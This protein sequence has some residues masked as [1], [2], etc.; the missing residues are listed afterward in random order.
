MIF[1]TYLIRDL[2]TDKQI[3]KRRIQFNSM[4]WLKNFA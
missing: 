1:N 4:I 3:V 2:E